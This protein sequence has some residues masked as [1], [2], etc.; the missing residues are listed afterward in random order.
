M[1]ALGCIQAQSC[2]TDRCP[3]GIATQDPK[4]WKQLDIPDKATRVFQ[5]HDNT[6]KALRELLCAAGLEHPAQLTPEHIMRRVSQYEIRSVGALYRFLK[7]GDLINQ[8]PDHAVFQDFWAKARSDSFQAHI[9]G[10][11]ERPAKIIEAKLV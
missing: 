1:F 8:V 6:L 7:P 9:E 2:H 11:L 3:T 5:Y 4:R 10:V